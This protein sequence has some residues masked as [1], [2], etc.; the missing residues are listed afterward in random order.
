MTAMTAY[1]MICFLILRHAPFRDKMPCT[2]PLMSTHHAIR[3][4]GVIHAAE[5]ISCRAK[6]PD[7]RFDEIREYD[8]KDAADDLL[9]DHIFHGLSSL[10]VLVHAYHVPYG[11]NEQEESG[12]TTEIRKYGE[13][14]D[15]DQRFVVYVINQG[16][17]VEEPRDRV[18]ENHDQDRGSTQEIDAGEATLGTSRHYL[19][20]CLL[21]RFC[22]L[23]RHMNAQL[24]GVLM[25][26]HQTFTR[27]ALIWFGTSCAKEVGRNKA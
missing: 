11:R 7:S 19:R 8:E 1:A 23:F 20:S 9:D 25:G 3:P 24:R 13:C 17:H 5:E 4:R 18:Q 27:D 6:V 12:Q 26:D 14:Q 10:E 22:E 16:I 2:M 15:V 21:R